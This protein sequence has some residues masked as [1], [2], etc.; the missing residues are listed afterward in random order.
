[1]KFC[2]SKTEIL[3]LRDKDT[4]LSYGKK[5]EE[6][7]IAELFDNSI[8]NVDKPKGLTSHQV[9]EIAKILT[10][11]RKSGHSGTLDVNVTGVLPVLLNNATKVAQAFTFLRKKYVGILR[12]HGDVSDNEIEQ[13]FIYFTGEIYQKPPQ[14]SAVKRCLRIREIHSLKIL[15][16]EGREILFEVE[17]DSGT[18]IRKLCHDI[19]LISGAGANMQALRR[20]RAGSFDESSITTLHELSDAFA[21]YKKGD[22]KPLRTV[23]YPVE[24]SVEQFRKIWV[25]D[26]AVDALCNGSKLYA[27]GV[28]KLHSNI[29]K[30]EHIAI[31]SLKDELIALGKSELS[32]EEIAKATSG[33]V[34][35]T[36]RVIMNRGTYPKSWKSNSQD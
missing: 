6:R 30:N 9:S 20:T 35:S 26:G 8:V 25:S 27:S 32:A 19:G 31:M 28:C 29:Q 3:I 16:R 2:D 5:P 24:K 10:L 14:K 7:T 4:D 17:C 36:E 13:I 18:Y 15:E 33:I 21:L 22:E 1:M 34:S 23:I 12:L 11:G